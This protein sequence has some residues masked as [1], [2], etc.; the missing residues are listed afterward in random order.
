MADAR[1]AMSFSRSPLNTD[2]FAFSQNVEY[3]YSVH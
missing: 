1:G 2:A 3:F